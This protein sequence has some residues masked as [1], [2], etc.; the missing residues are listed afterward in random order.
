M[1]SDIQYVMVTPVQA[2]AL[3]ERR[4]LGIRLGLLGTI[5]ALLLLAYGAFQLWGWLDRNLLHWGIETTS[6]TTVNEGELLERIR[7]FEVVSVKRTYLASSQVDVD[8][9][10]GAGPLRVGLPGWIAGQELEVKGQVV[11]SAGVD[12]SG[13]SAED[14]VVTRQ[15]EAVQVLINVPPAAVLSREILPGTMDID[16]SQGVLTRLRTR[17]GLSE[18]DLRD[19]A[20]DRLMLTA[21]EAALKGGILDDASQEAKLQLEGFLNGLALAQEQDVRYVVQVRE[22]ALF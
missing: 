2:A 13:V 3:K 4:G 22:E 7:A 11:V 8:K 14:G 21:E 5:A 1:S 16:T 10:L 18:Q 9:A 6:V 19:G 20:V 12:L 17:I 15:G